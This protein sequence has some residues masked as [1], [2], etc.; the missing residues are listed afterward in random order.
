MTNYTVTKVAT[1]QS[2]F[3][4]HSAAV[5]ADIDANPGATRA[6]IAT[7]T[8]KSAAIV[9]GVIAIALADG[10]LQQGYDVAGAEFFW[11]SADWQALMLANI[12][13]ARTWLAS[14]DNGLTSALATTLSVHE[15]IAIRLAFQLEAEGSAK[16]TAN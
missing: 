7:R 13:G 12:A 4:T 9:N 8:G 14:N 5:Y 11:T 3:A 10:L 1:Y 6:G 15:A 16:L 2:I